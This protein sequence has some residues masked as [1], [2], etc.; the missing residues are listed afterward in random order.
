MFLGILREFLIYFASISA[1]VFLANF[2]GAMLSF[3]VV[4][5][6]S[7][8]VIG[9]AMISAITVMN[10]TRRLIMNVVHAYRDGRLFKR[11]ELKRLLWIL[12]WCSVLIMAY[13]LLN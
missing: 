5:T 12:F 9:S 7:V 13:S 10:W 6:S 3:P 4:V 1:W 2:F 11:S 8:V